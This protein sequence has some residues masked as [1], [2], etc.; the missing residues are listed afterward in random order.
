MAGF[1]AR[2]IAALHSSTKRISSSASYHRPGRRCSQIACVM[3]RSGGAPLLASMTARSRIRLRWLRITLPRL[4]LVLVAPLDLRGAL[5]LDDL[6]GPHDI[7]ERVEYG[8]LDDPRLRHVMIP[9][10]LF[11]TGLLLLVIRHAHR[12]AAFGGLQGQLNLTHSWGH[13]RDNHT[14]RWIEPDCGSW[15][16]VTLACSFGLEVPRIATI[17]VQAPFWPAVHCSTWNDLLIQPTAWTLRPPLPW[18]GRL[19]VDSESPGRGFPLIPDHG[20]GFLPFGAIGRS[21]VYS[22]PPILNRQYA[23]GFHVHAVTVYDP[24]LTA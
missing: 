22:N 8:S 11:S 21:G 18:I 20:S 9:F 12:P 2:S 15:L 16:R 5:G 7:R 10:S 6:H 13:A 14:G 19:P 3:A 4:P 23:G 1:R 24:R 17:F